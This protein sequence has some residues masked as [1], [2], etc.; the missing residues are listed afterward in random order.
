MFLDFIYVRVS[1]AIPFNNAEFKFLC[2][3]LSRHH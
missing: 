1:R 2:L 3:F